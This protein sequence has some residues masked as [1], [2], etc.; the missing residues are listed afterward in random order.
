MSQTTSSKNV[1]NLRYGMNPH[2]KQAKL[3]S[4]G[5][6]PVKVLNGDP[7]FINLLDA[8][9]GFQL[10]RELRRATGLPAAASFKH[11]SPAG[12]AVAAPLS[13]ELKKAYFV[14]GLEL[15]PL[16]TA[17]ARARGADRM[18]SFG[19]AAALSDIVDAS[20]AQLLKREVS[21]L[22]VAPGYTDE[23]LEILKAKKN[24]GYL[25]L[26]IDPDY[27][28]NPIETRTLFGLTLQQERNDAVIDESALEKKSL[29]RTKS[30]RNM[31]SGIF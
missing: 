11:V 15:S 2:Q 17:Y 19:D 23:A 22:V 30:C 12:A 18:S 28:P 10:A 24:G 13:P 1:L 20:T 16:A 14:E 25:I 29:R 27:V 8:L 6:L 31:R 9:N 26:Q 5:A 21:D 3:I 4:E 7:G